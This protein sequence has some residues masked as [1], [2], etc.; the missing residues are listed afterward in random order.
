MGAEK[1]ST[2][3]TK[4]NTVT[5]QTLDKCDLIASKHLHFTDME[6]VPPSTGIFL[7]KELENENN[8]NDYLKP[9]KQKQQLQTADTT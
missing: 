1:S 3:Q 4:L 8:L 7:Q 9:H 2:N 6:L 5:V